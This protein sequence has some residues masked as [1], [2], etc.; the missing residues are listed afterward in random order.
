MFSLWAGEARGAAGFVLC[1]A[2]L[3]VVFVEPLSR[4]QG[5][6]VSSDPSRCAIIVMHENP[7][8]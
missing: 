3:K 6:A 7:R 4:G 5:A 1:G 8:A 2:D